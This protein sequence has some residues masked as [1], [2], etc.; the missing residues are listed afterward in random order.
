MPS[1]QPSVRRIDS[2][3]LSVISP[4]AYRSVTI[5]MAGLSSGW[6]HP[7][8]C[9]TLHT[10]KSIIPS[11]NQGTLPHAMIEGCL[12]T[13]DNVTFGHNLVAQNLSTFV[14]L[15]DGISNAVPWVCDDGT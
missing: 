9:R 11:Q 6:L 2:Y 14:D 8:N 4:L 7:A 10:T 1:G 3:S 12:Y 13:P 5:S 15:Q